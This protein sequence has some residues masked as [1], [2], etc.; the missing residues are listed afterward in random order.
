MTRKETILFLI[1]GL[2]CFSTALLM[3]WDHWTWEQGKTGDI[4]AM[5]KALGGLGMGAIAGP[6]WNF[7]N[8]D[9]RIMS[10]DDALTWP[11]PGGYSFGP[12]RTA[13]I[14]YFE[15]NPQKGWMEARRN[16]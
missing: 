16:Q 7:I 14:T 9:P 13:T 6:V 4:K 10:Y 3:V 11:I 5:Q 15:E 8:Y 12:D 1:L 2:L